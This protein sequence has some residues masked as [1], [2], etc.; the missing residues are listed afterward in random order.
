MVDGDLL[1]TIFTASTVLFVCVVCCKWCMIRRDYEIH[2]I[3]LESMP[4]ATAPPLS[5]D[6]EP[7]PQEEDEPSVSV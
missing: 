6:Y 1:S 3:S 2:S 4:Q 7:L 5:F